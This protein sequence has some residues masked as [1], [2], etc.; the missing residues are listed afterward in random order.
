MFILAYRFGGNTALGFSTEREILEGD[1]I[2][3]EDVRREDGT[4]VIE[5][6]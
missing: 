3:Y 4:R 5:K 1:C 6:K 2:A